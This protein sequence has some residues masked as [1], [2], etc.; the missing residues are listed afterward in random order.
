[1][2]IQ[3]LIDSERNLQ[4]EAETR[5]CNFLADSLRRHM[6][7]ADISASDLARKTGLKASF[8]YDVLKGKSANP[9][10]LKMA[11]VADALNIELADMLRGGDSSEQSSHKT[12]DSAPIMNFYDGSPAM[13]VSRKCLHDELDAD[14][15]NLR[16][17][18]LSG[19]SLVSELRTGD[20]II[21]D[22]SQHS[23]SSSG[24][25]LYS[26]GVSYTV[27]KI[28]M[29]ES[30]AYL[31]SDDQRHT[32]RAVPSENISIIGRVIWFGRK[33]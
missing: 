10:L 33:L 21:V 29:V 9:S 22:V 6:Q 7:M 11:I 30:G 26:D 32:G 16:C 27:G 8:I 25:F 1:M 24:I 15:E 19:K 5:N 13:S 3:P 17:L 20:L 23:P 2:L 4:E 28:F 31:V 14:P 18:T 12:N